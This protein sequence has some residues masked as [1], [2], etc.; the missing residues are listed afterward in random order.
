[1]NCVNRWL[2]RGVTT[3]YVGLSD[4]LGKAFAASGSRR[5]GRYAGSSGSFDLRTWHLYLFPWNGILPVSLVPLSLLYLFQFI[6]LSLFPFLSEFLLFPCTSVGDNI[7]AWVPQF[8][9]SFRIIFLCNK[10]TTPIT[11]LAGNTIDIYWWIGVYLC[12]CNI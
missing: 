10:K 12:A 9:R 5:W 6:I 7:R 4:W 2:L 1:M 3:V 8:Q 11:K